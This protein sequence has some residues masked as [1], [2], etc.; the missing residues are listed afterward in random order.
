VLCARASEDV[1]LREIWQQDV[2]REALQHEFLL[3]GILSLA[4]VHIISTSGDFNK[5]RRIARIHQEA[6]LTAFIPALDNL[7]KD[8]CHALFIFSTILAILS[9]ASPMSVATGIHLSPID[10]ALGL[11][12]L[13]RGV[14][15]VVKGSYSWIAGGRMGYMLHRSENVEEQE[16]SPDVIAGFD[17]LR[18]KLNATTDDSGTLEVYKSATLTLE[19]TFRRLTRTELDS[20]TILNWSDACGD[21]YIALLKQ[22]QLPAL[23][24]LA[25]YGVLLHRLKHEWWIHAWG[26]QLV[27]A[28]RQELREDWSEPIGW[29]KGQTRD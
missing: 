27:E 2:I 18:A 10:K 3:H 15:A 1:Q 11:L 14:R 9:V 12:V 17:I 21:G 29:A 24:I 25:Y 19:D 8:N 22:R 28:V 23:A 26:S 6:G 7:N 5:W 20:G 16:L 4:A 13:L